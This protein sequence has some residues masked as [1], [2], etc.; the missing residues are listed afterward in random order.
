[1]GL[2]PVRFRYK[3]H[4]PEGPEQ[5]GLIAE[6]VEEVAPDLVGHG[7]DGQI[8]SVHYDKVNVILLNEVQKQH[9]VMEAQK[10]ELQ[11]QKEQLQTQA[12]LIRE[13][14]SRLAELEGREK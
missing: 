13:I 8:D 7:Q 14:Q 10:E 2:R 3:A 5:Y 12:D 6:E 11:A 4:G 9:R 1:M